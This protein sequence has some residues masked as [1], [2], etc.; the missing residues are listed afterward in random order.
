LVATVNFS[1]VL[2][3]NP[4]LLP[5]NNDPATEEPGVM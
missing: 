4:G 3:D 5:Q 2:R 1:E